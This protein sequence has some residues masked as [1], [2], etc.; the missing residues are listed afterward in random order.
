MVVVGRL[1]GGTDGL[2]GFIFS[3]NQ[4]PIFGQNGLGLVRATAVT[5]GVERISE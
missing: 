1:V 5:E 2:V 4:L 3:C